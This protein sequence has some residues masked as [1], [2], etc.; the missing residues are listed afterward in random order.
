[1]TSRG[2]M[3]RKP[4][5]RPTGSKAPRDV[6]DEN[7]KLA[8]RKAWRGGGG[9][10]DGKEGKPGEAKGELAEMKRIDGLGAAAKGRAKDLDLARLRNVQFR[11]QLEQHR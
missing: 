9:K 1:M 4:R 3:P 10:G 8:E 2:M 6:G 5:T 11:R 7:Q